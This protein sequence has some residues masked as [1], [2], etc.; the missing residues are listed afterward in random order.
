MASYDTIVFD[1]GG[2]LIDWNPAYVYRTIF[3]DPAEMAYFLTEVCSSEWNEQQDAGRLQSEGTEILVQQFPHYEPQI[4]AFYDR[5]EEML[6]G[7]IQDTVEL[8]RELHAANKHR[9]YALTNW[10]RENFPVALQRYDF[11]QLFQ[12]ILVSGEEKMK[13]PDPAIFNL[14]AQ[15]YEIT[16]PSAIFIDDNLRNVHAAG[17]LGF[18]SIHFQSAGDLRT[19]LNDLGVV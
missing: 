13:K 7:P 9:L 15:R 3:D 4:R 6:G 10:S 2:V 17:D 5:W 19:I 11:L 1:L 16:P 18:Q 8:L 14:L 12:G